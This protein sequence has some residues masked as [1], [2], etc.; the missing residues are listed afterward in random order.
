M[1]KPN[2]E[3][4]A[5]VPSLRVKMQE[6]ETEA[7]A[8]ARTLASPAINAGATT[9]EFHPLRKMG[10]LNAVIQEVEK[11][12]AAVVGGDLAR[13]ETMLVAQA[14]TLDTLFNSLA[15]LSAKCMGGTNLQAADTYMRLALRA[16]S[17]CRTTWEALAE[18]KN[19]TRPTFIKQQNVAQNQQVNN[20]P[21]TGNPA[22]VPARTEE[23][24]ITPTNEL[25]EASH[26]ERLDFGAASA[27]GRANS[28]LATVGTVNGTK[29]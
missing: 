27:A 23:K 17:Q 5:E 15:M 10:D 12:A 29:D 8:L 24:D 20:G 14:H 4:A 22:S 16:Q 9:M 25:L 13:A 11:Q 3:A 28:D 18:I 6:G 2:Q 26:G 1:S 7:G 19:P 21:I